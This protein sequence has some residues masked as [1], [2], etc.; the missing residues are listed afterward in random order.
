MKYIIL[1][2]VEVNMYTY[3]HVFVYSIWRVFPRTKNI[4]N[5]LSSPILSFLRPGNP[6]QEVEWLN[7]GRLLRQRQNQKS[8]HWP[9]SPGTALMSRQGAQ[10]PPWPVL[11]WALNK[12]GHKAAWHYLGST[13]SRGQSWSA[14]K[15]ASCPSQGLPSHMTIACFASNS[16]KKGSRN[17]WGS[18]PP[19]LAAQYLEKVFLVLMLLSNVFRLRLIDFKYSL[20]RVSQSRC[21]CFSGCFQ[22]QKKIK[23][24]VHVSTFTVKKV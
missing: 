13:L 18:A 4:W 23:V 14:Q 1:I 2:Y 15:W 20:G 21:P 3:T 9:V 17:D 7:L 6:I 12:S 22:L 11:C 16:S 19:S 24:I 10:P 8:C 5:Y